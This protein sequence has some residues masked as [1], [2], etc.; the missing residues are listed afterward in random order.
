MYKVQEHGHGQHIYAYA[1]D[2]DQVGYDIAG[3][4]RSESTPDDDEE[5]EFG[6]DDPPGAPIYDAAGDLTQLFS[7]RAEVYDLAASGTNDDALVGS[8]DEDVNYEPIA[9]R[10]TVPVYDTAGPAAGEDEQGYLVP[11]G[12]LYSSVKK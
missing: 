11:A 5:D 1:A 7:P 3:D 4:T 10:S 6:L 8:D 12:A 9:L 2:D